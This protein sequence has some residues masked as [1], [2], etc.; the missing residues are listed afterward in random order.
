[1]KHLSSPPCFLWH[2]TETWGTSDYGSGD[3]LSRAKQAFMFLWAPN[4]QGI[5][6]WGEFSPKYVLKAV[7]HSL[8]FTVEMRPR[9]FPTGD[10]IP[11]Q[12]GLTWADC[13]SI[14]VMGKALRTIVFQ[15]RISAVCE[16]WLCPFAISILK[17]NGAN[18]W[19]KMSP[20]GSIN[21]SSTPQL[22]AHHSC[23]L[24]APIQIIHCA[25]FPLVLHFYSSLTAV[26]SILQPHLQSRKTDSEQSRNFRR[27]C[28]SILVSTKKRKI[29]V[30]EN[31]ALWIAFLDCCGRNI[32]IMANSKLPMCRHWIWSRKGG[33]RYFSWACR[34]S[35]RDTT[36]DRPSET[37]RCPPCRCA[38]GY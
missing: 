8:K 29:L 27:P 22:S 26:G 18:P 7:I 2:I 24:Q 38:Q 16:H 1:M 36:E 31:K 9:D 11:D 32:A 23:F 5:T 17:P 34:T 35:S 14:L 30:S 15:N 19:S 33:S 4:I 21:G 12:A 28:G 10:T 20:S 6:V 3:F 25:P 37:R 13:S